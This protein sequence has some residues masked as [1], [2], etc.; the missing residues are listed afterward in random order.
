[1]NLR[2][3]GD[4]RSQGQCFINT[5][6]NNYFRDALMPVLVLGIITDTRIEYC[7]C[8]H[9]VCANTMSQTPVVYFLY[10]MIVK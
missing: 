8:N 3:S 9:K 1:M 4:L 2:E 6:L 10:M 5:L 7:A